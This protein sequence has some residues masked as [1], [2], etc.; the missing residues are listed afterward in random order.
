MDVPGRRAY[1]AVVSYTL[2]LSDAELD[3]Y[4][5]MAEHARSSESDL[6]ALAGLRPG[7]RVADVGCGPGALFPALV[8][9]IGPGGALVGVDGDDDAVGAARSV[10]DSFGWTN[11]S[12]VRGRAERSGLEPASF[13]VVM[14]RHVLAHNARQ[15]QAI[16]D[17]LA[18]L[19]RPGGMVYLVDVFA[20]MVRTVPADDDFDAM[21]AA[22]VEF[23]HRQGNDLQTGSRL[24]ELARTAG[25]DVVAYRG[26]LDIVPLVPGMRPPAFAARA[27]MVEAGVVT[28]EQVDRWE[29]TMDDFLAS[30]HR[31]FAPLFGCVA[32]A[33]D[34]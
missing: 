3:R 10:V 1:V 30:P 11:V 25:L 7:A 8:D 4:R 32:R 5:L 6:W 20:D 9:A 19:A 12:V 22:Y 26:W 34:A 14:M 31:L 24:D 2:R 27:A 13:D 18:T 28:Q 23:H 17:H 21:N 15:E 29:A 33:P 16:V